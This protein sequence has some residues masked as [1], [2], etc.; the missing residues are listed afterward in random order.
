MNIWLLFA[1]S[2]KNEYEL[3]AEPH[4]AK[5]NNLKKAWHEV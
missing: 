4:I 2:L 3:G 1:P 5:Q